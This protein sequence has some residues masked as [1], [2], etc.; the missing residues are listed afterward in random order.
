MIPRM[1]TDLTETPAPE[2]GASGGPGPA[3]APLPEQAILVHIG[4]HKTGTTTIQAAFHASRDALAAQGVVYAGGGRRPI[5][6]VLALRGAHG[7]RTAV[8]ELRH[9]SGLVDEARAATGRV[10]ISNESFADA[11]PRAIAK[12]VRDLGPERLHVVATLRPLASI[13]PSQWQQFVKGGLTAGFDE[14]LRG[15]IDPN[16]P[17][18]RK[19]F[20]RRHQHHELVARWAEVVGPERVTV[21]VLDEDPVRLPRLFEGLLG[22]RDG[23]LA[24]HATMRNRSLTW[25]ETEAIRTIN[26]AFRAAAYPP[27]LQTQLVARGISRHLLRR[28]P[29]RAEPRIDVPAWAVERVAMVGREIVAGL[30]ASRVRIIGDVDR[31]LTIPEP[32]PSRASAPSRVSADLAG[33]VSMAAV[34]T[35][36]AMGKRPPPIEPGEFDGIPSARLAGVLVHRLLGIPRMTW[37]SIR[38]STGAS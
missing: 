16:D 25:P 20:W 37:R 23:T 26:K 35:L 13:L 34:D 9:W 27:A 12:L 2:P 7:R 19:V 33:A 22:L 15:V 18:R 1:A 8:P 32:H 5:L 14:W 24:E 11:S 10:V 6:A 30:L 36:S 28:E 38:G 31:L 21:I 17:A 29:D 4:P 3:V